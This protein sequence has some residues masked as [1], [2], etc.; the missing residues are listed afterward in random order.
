MREISKRDGITPAAL[1]ILRASVKDLHALFS[2]HVVKGKAL[3]VH[4]PHVR[5]FILTG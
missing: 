5:R 2:K 3:K 4:R 1:E